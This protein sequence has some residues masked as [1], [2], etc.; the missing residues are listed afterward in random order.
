MRKI[1]PSAPAFLA[2]S[3]FIFGTAL[4][5]GVP[6][7]REALEGLRTGKVIFDVR[8]P[9]A[10]KLTFNLEL[11][12]ETFEGMRDQG[13]KPAMIVTFRGPTV[14]LLTRERAS[15]WNAPLIIELKKMGVRFEACAVAT[16]IFKVDNASLIPEVILV[17]NV[18]TSLIGYQN[19][20]YALIP[21]Y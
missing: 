7:D 20:G 10:E 8:V 2:F 17:G 6:N 21:V 18:L 5:A 15:E 4:W 12:K 13:V 1:S 16:R 9:D 19:K 3:L 11:I 14:R